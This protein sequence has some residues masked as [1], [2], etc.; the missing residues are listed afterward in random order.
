MNYTVSDESRS[1]D[2]IWWISDV[3]RFQNDY[4]EWS[5]RYGLRDIVEEIVVAAKNRSVGG[6]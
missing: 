1:G 4:P 6:A 5:Y 2:H 3:R